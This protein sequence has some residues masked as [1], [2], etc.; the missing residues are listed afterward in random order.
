MTFFLICDILYIMKIKQTIFKIATILLILIFF[1]II[2]YVIG[3]F[4]IKDLNIQQFAMVSLNGNLLYGGYGEYILQS[5]PL[6][7]Y[8]GYSTE[9]IAGVTKYKINS[10]GFRGEEFSKIK[11][12]GKIRIIFL[13][14]SSM[15]NLGWED[16]STTIV[17]ELGKKDNIIE[18]LNCGIPGYTSSQELALLIHEMIDYN[19]DIVISLTGWNDINWGIITE[20]YQGLSPL[21][22]ELDDSLERFISNDQKIFQN[23]ILGFIN[24]LNK[25]N[26]FRQVSIKLKNKK[27]IQ[28]EKEMD[29]KYSK[30]NIDKK[31]E[32]IIQYFVNNCYKMKKISSSFSFKYIVFLQPTVVMKE[33]PS[34]LEIKITQ[35]KDWSIYYS[36]AK[37]LYSSY[38]G[39]IK[40]KLNNKEI[41]FVDIN[42][43][44]RFIYSNKTLFIDDTHTNKQGN[45]IIA[46]IIYQT[47]LENEILEN[48]KTK[49]E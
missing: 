4:P 44:P 31:A 25:S 21:Y 19:P 32:T 38:F 47:L 2:D 1:T 49:S 10:K 34:K 43:D 14:G 3:K 33:T 22:N 6:V 24:L 48:N 41:M 37:Y 15:F 16:D 36:N 46:E 7:F 39:K 17:K 27:L 29:L 42:K 45:Q 8:K 9:K 12:P 11:P 5:Q 30:E 26:I 20:N 18:V 13:G 23:I 35:D 40:E 28:R